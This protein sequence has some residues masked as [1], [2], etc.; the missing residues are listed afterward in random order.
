MFSHF[1]KHFPEKKFII[2]EKHTGSLF[3]KGFLA[4]FP[5]KTKTGD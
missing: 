3:P 2:K 1:K 5:P 4:I